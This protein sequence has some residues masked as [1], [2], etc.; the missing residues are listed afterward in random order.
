MKKHDTGAGHSPYTRLAVMA[1]ASFVAMYTLMY[2]MVDRFSNA[3][4]NLNQAYMAG[5]MTAPMVV[6]E[7]VVMWSMYPNRRLNGALLVAS[8]VMLGV[9]WTSIRAQAA[10]TDRQFLKSMI[11]HHASAILMC[12]ETSLRDPELERLCQGIVSSQQREI[13]FMKTKLR[14]TASR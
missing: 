1:A 6:I 5:L 12:Q 2:A 9:C 8:A 3:L 11:P 10:I 13:D 14:Q 4:P 7:L